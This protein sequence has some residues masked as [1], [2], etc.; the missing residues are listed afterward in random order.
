MMDHDSRRGPLGLVSCRYKAVAAIDRWRALEGNTKAEAGRDS[1]SRP[2]IAAN[3][4][5]GRWERGLATIFEIGQIGYLANDFRRVCPP[6]NSRYW[7]I[8]TIFDQS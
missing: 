6:S 5:R 7:L 4:R 1:R 3:P 8:A 2:T